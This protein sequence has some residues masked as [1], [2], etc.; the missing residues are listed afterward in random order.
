MHG[1]LDVVWIDNNRCLRTL[2]SSSTAQFLVNFDSNTRNWIQLAVI[3]YLSEF[4][5]SSQ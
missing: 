3:D 4:Y 2:T 1:W 5:R